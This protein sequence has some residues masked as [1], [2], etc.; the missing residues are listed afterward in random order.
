MNAGRTH[1]VGRAEVAGTF[2]SADE[3]DELEES[4]SV[5]LSLLEM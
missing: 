1:D 3:T 4:P 2:A 5:T